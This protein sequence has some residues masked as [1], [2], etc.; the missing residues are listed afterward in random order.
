MHGHLGF[1]LK[2]V[3]GLLLILNIAIRIDG[4]AEFLIAGSH[5]RLHVILVLLVELVLSQ[6]KARRVLGRID[7]F[8]LLLQLLLLLLFEFLFLGGL[9][10]FLLVLELFE[11]IAAVQYSMTEL[12][13]EVLVAQQ[14]LDA[15]IDE[16]EM[17]QSIDGGA[18]FTVL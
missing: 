1:I 7:D 12:F 16:R 9:L 3:L 13:L 11:Y 10:G 8:H 6:A 14:L 15:A 2:L 17:K 5:D 4:L 18:A